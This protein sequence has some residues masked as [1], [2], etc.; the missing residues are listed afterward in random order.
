MIKEANGFRAV[1]LSD[2]R[3]IAQG[4]AG[5]LEECTVWLFYGEMGSGKTTLIKE[6]CKAVGVV[7]AMSS[8]TY[9]IINEYEK[10]DHTKVFH[11][12]FYRIKHEAEAYDIG[13]GSIFIPGALVL[14]SGRK[15]YRP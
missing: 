12:D 2:L 11:F 1:S 8:P 14:S 13:V 15:K 5:Q 6:I 3:E 7:D 9:A 4:I 10:D